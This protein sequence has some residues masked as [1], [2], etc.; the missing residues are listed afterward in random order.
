M[1]HKITSKKFIWRTSAFLILSLMLASL[2][3]CGN[4]AGEVTPP[5]V[6]PITSEPD[7]DENAD[8]ASATD[9]QNAESD[10]AENSSA[11]TSSGSQ[12]FGSE[13]INGDPAPHNNIAP[14]SDTELEGNVK[15]IGEDSFVVSQIFTMPSEDSKEAEIMV[16]PAEGSEDEVLI[17]VHVSENTLYQIHTVKNGGVNGDAD[18]EKTDAEFA[19]IREKNSITALGYYKDNDFWADN[20]IIYRFV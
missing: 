17:T 1:Q 7:S 15:S 14:Q 20:I 19:D 6:E 5:T 13:Q 2:T 8:P 3:G 10:S 11:E 18:V 9:M 12:N 16:S 4:T